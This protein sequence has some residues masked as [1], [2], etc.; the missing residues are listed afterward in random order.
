MKIFAEKG[1]FICI[2][3]PSASGKDTLIARLQ[4]EYIKRNKQVFI[5]SE[6]EL[7]PHR[8]EI[9]TAKLD[10]Q[11]RWG[12]TGDYGMAV[13]LCY[14]RAEIY[15]KELLPRIRENINVIANRGLPATMAYQTARHEISKFQVLKLN[16]Q[17]RIR[18]PD[19]TVI[20]NCLPETAQNREQNRSQNI[21]GLS[22]SV[23]QEKGSNIAEVFKRRSDIHRNYEE[24]GR[25]LSSHYFNVIRLSSEYLTL[26]EEVSIVIRQLSL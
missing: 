15:R 8:E 12:G 18:H 13:A 19:L 26:D 2:D 9:K 6:D 22:G 23:T 4:Q 5:L 3:G 25:F 1:K 7:D 17:L 21:I 16:D 24:T 14:H 20:T 11:A 10:W